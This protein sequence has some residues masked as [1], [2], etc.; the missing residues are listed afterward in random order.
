MHGG[1]DFNAPKVLPS[2]AG[3]GWDT[4]ELAAAIAALPVLDSDSPIRTWQLDDAHEDVDEDACS[5]AS[6]PLFADCSSTSAHKILSS[7]N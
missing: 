5:A 7:Y 1:N 3:L 4:A 2:A 6:D